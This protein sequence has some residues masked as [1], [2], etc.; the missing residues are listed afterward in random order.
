MEFNVKSTAKPIK[1]GDLSIQSFPPEEQALAW[2][3]PPPLV[4]GED[5]AQYEHVLRLVAHAM[6]PVDIVDWFWVRDV[7][8]LEWEV[9]RLRKIKA[10]MISQ[11]KMIKPGIDEDGEPTVE[12]GSNEENLACAIRHSI[13]TLERLDRLIMALEVRRDRVYRESERRGGSATR[14]H[15]AAKQIEDAE[16]CEIE[17][18]DSVQKRAA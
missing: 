14:L 17:Q 8:D 2:M 16:F 6:K 11:E 18:N 12:E 7:T 15:R 13:N 9:V 5:P 10:F 1:G 4:P 3:G